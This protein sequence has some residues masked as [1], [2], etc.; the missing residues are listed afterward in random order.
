ML[1]E[2]WQEARLYIG[3]LAFPIALNPNPIHRA[4]LQDDVFQVEGDVIFRMASN[5]ASLATGA[6]V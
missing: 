1:A 6:A 2:H 5:D 4:L 3:I